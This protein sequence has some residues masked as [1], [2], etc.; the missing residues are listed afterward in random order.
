[1]RGRI[2][3]GWLTASGP[4]FAFNNAV[5]AVAGLDLLPEDGDV[6]VGEERCVQG[7][8]RLPWSGGGM[9]AEGERRFRWGRLYRVAS[10]L[11]VAKVFNLESLQCKGWSNAYGVGRTWPRMAPT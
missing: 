3:N 1:M 5:H 10:D 8:F 4:V 7:V 11:R 9:S 2:A 6:R